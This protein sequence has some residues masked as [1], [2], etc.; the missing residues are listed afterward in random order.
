[1]TKIKIYICASCRKKPISRSSLAKLEKVGL[2]VD[3][4][5]LSASLTFIKTYDR[6]FG[7]DISLFPVILVVVTG[8]SLLIFVAAETG[9]SEPLASKMVSASAAIPAFRHCLPSR[10]LASDHIPS[11]YSNPFRFSD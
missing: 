11:Q 6:F 3:L 7:L 4:E 2:S 9:V 8:M 5:L 10:C 1:M